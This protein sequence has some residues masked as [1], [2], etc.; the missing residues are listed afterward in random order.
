MSEQKKRPWG[1]RGTWIH[2]LISMKKNYGTGSGYIDRPAFYFYA[3]EPQES[4]ALAQ[5]WENL[6][7]RAEALLEKYGS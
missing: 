2:S 3:D 6:R 7:L 4:M 1:K 5:E